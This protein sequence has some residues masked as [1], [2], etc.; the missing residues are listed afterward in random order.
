V[1]PI[2][3]R[4]PSPSVSHL[5]QAAHSHCLPFT[6]RC[7]VPVSPIY[8]KLPSPSVSHLLQAAHSHCLPFTSRCPV[9]VSLIYFTLPSPS[10]SHLLHAAQSQCFPFIIGNYP[11]HLALYTL[12]QQQMFKKNGGLLKWCRSVDRRNWFVERRR[13]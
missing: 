2:Y 10:V 12:S 8:S 3:S 13:R 7:P 4:L 1:S 9:P 6:S 11:R 5:L